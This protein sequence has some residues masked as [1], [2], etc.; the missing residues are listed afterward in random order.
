MSI[1]SIREVFNAAAAPYAA[2]F[3]L[4][5][6]VRANGIEWNVLT[7]RGIGPDGADFEIKSNRIRPEGS[8]IEAAQETAE[9]L[10]A[11]TPPPAEQPR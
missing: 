8:L 10:K 6:T 2:T 1:A 9:R 3:T 7:F 5:D 11:R 4:M